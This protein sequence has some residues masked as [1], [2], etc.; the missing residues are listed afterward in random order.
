MKRIATNALKNGPKTKHWVGVSSNFTQVG[1]DTV[2][3]LSPNGSNSMNI[4][5]DEL[6]GRS[7]T[8]IE[9]VVE[10]HGYRLCRVGKVKLWFEK[11]QG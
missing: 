2:R 6:K 3:R 11:V 8:E 10:E 9:K 5:E 4:P 1:I 7:I